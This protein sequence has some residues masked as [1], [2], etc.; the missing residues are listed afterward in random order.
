M[1]NERQVEYDCVQ[2]DR[3]LAFMETSGAE[4][5]ILILDACRN[6]PFERSWSRSTS[7]NGLASMSAPKGTLIAYA[8]SPGSTASDG[9]RRLGLYTEAI[10][11]NIQIPSITALKMFQNV[12]GIVSDRSHN[13]QTPW[14]STS[15]TG[16]F[17]F[18]RD[19]S[20][21]DDLQTIPVNRSDI[22]L[23][24]EEFGPEING[25]FLDVRDNQSY[26][27]IRFGPYVWMAENLNY[28][29]QEGSW[30]YNDLERNCKSFGRLYNWETA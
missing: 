24:T 12:R 28:R 14:E 21:Q 8:T 25:V 9:D 11:E 19:V 4:V 1:L 23:S 10:I 7:G 26:E 5:N 20:T 6:N 17:Y 15:L 22:L 27:W 18:V 16:D 3:I 13:Q 30:C 2:A 29:T